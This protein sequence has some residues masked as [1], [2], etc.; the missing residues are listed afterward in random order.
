[1]D[2]GVDRC[3]LGSLSC[4]LNEAVNTAL[5]CKQSTSILVSEIQIYLSL[6]KIFIK[7]IREINQVKE[8]SSSF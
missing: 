7:K 2:G 3:A 5:S 1:M 6:F 8:E 4:P